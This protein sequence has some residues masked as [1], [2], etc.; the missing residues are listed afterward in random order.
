MTPPQKRHVSLAYK[1]QAVA[2]HKT[3]T[4]PQKCLQSNLKTLHFHFLYVRNCHTVLPKM[5]IN[6]KHFGVWVIVQRA[7]NLLCMWPTQVQ[8]PR[9]HIVL[10]VTSGVI[11]ACRVR[12]KPWTLLGVATKQSKTKIRSFGGMILHPTSQRKHRSFYLIK[13]A[14]R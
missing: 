10:W 8:F 9:M 1:S 14:T 3:K 6:Q 13:H 4:K 12:K 2:S 5:K 7:G 11:F